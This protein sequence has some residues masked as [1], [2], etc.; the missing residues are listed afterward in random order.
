MGKAGL[1]KADGFT[2]IHVLLC[3]HEDLCMQMKNSGVG[4]SATLIKPSLKLTHKV[5]LIAIKLPEFGNN[6][7]H[8]NQVYTEAC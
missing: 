8:L 7:I 5:S 6:L 3:C 4:G 1:I 2:M